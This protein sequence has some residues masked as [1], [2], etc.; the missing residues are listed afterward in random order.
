MLSDIIYVFTSIQKCYPCL[1]IT[2]YI[3]ESG[4][5]ATSSVGSWLGLDKGHGV[6]PLVNVGLFASINKYLKMEET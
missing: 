4:G 1:Q 6:N 3:I 5:A 2:S